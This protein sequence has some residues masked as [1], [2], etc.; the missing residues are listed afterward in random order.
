LLCRYQSTTTTTMSS[1]KDT[2][3]GAVDDTQEMIRQFQSN[4]SLLGFFQRPDAKG[5]DVSFH[6]TNTK[7]M[8]SVLHFLLTKIY[9]QQASKVCA[10]IQQR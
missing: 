5:L 9:A 1:S 2:A 7:A 3:G 10:T 8:Q 4:L 6:R